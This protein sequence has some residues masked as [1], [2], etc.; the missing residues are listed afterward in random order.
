MLELALGFLFKLCMPMGQK[1]SST[2]LPEHRLPSNWRLQA[3][4][5]FYSTGFRAGLQHRE[6]SLIF[7][8]TTTVPKEADL[9]FL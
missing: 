8:S 2:L 3:Y 1:T 5:Q 9:T 7:F 6:T 4:A